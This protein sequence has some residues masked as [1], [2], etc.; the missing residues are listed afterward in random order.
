M[1]Y[2]F[3]KSEIAN[4]FKVR[5]TKLIY[6]NNFGL[7]SYFKELVYSKIKAA[8]WFGILFDENFQN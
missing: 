6:I 5:W 3:S 8:N 4:G 2:T 1:H 7:V